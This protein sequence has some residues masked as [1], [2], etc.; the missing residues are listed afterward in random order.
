MGR[1]RMEYNPLH[2]YHTL[3]NKIKVPED[4]EVGGKARLDAETMTIFKK[5]KF[6]VPPDIK[7]AIE[8]HKRHRLVKTYDISIWTDV[9]V[10][11]DHGTSASAG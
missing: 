6:H 1:R 3:R 7:S 8:L 10:K 2:I 9:S 5:L 4:S 11:Y